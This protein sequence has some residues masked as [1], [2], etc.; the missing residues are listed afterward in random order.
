MKYPLTFVTV[1][2]ICFAGTC[3][4]SPFVE[5][6]NSIKVENRWIDTTK[7]YVSYIYPD[8]SI[9]TDM[10]RLK[11]IYPNSY[12]YYDSKKGFKEVF[13][14][15]PDDTLSI[16]IISLDT[17]KKY[18]W[19]TIRNSYNILKRYDVSLSDLEKLNWTITYPPREAMKDLKQFPPY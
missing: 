10:P 7:F 3:K 5:R 18:S 1:F 14:T 12:S 9:Q 15:L 4:R 16:F 19:P 2:L 17:I 6:V 8:T 13:K 11:F